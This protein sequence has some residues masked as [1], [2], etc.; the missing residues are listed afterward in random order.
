MSETDAGVPGPDGGSCVDVAPSGIVLTVPGDAGMPAC[1]DGK[2]GV[3]VSVTYDPGLVAGRDFQSIEA[4]I[5]FP[6]A[7][8]GGD[9]NEGSAYLFADVDAGAPANVWFPLALA[10]PKS[11]YAALLLYPHHSKADQPVGSDGDDALLP[12]QPGKVSHIAR[13]MTR[14]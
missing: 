4:V 2:T 9:P 10:E 8:D 13:T 3:L 7:V 1:L 6:N 11:A 14:H 5:G 12:V